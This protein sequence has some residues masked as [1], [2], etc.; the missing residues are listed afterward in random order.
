MSVTYFSVFSPEIFHT[1]VKNTFLSQKSNKFNSILKQKIIQEQT[2]IKTETNNFN[3]K[4]KTTY[5]K[6]TSNYFNTNTSNNINIRDIITSK[7]RKILKLSKKKNKYTISHFLNEK[8]QPYKQYLLEKRQYEN[9]KKEK[10]RYKSNFGNKN[11]LSTF[12]PNNKI[13]GINFATQKGYSELKNYSKNKINNKT[14]P[15]VMTKRNKYD[16]V[17]LTLLEDIKAGKRKN[18]FDENFY[19]KSIL[20]YDKFRQ[21]AISFMKFLNENPNYNY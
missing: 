7:K 3:N 1:E 5:F 18:V 20:R 16:E 17:D 4:T 15:I 8:I 9:I 11:D 14:R 19:I 12:Q 2:K 13:K 10:N 6:T 21:S